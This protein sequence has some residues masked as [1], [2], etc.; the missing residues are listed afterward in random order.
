MFL[1]VFTLIHII[2]VIFLFVL[3]LISLSIFVFILL[4]LVGRFRNIFPKQN[5]FLLVLDRQSID[6]V[7]IVV[8]SLVDKAV[9]NL[10][11]SFLFVLAVDGKEHWAVFRQA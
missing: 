1:V 11:E 6:Y 8:V 10:F 2:I 3:L 4:S 7:V 9:D 5:D